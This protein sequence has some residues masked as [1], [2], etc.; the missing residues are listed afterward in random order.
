MSISN[1]IYCHLPLSTDVLTKWGF[2]TII[3]ICAVI[4]MK[5]TSYQYRNFHYKD[6]TVSQLS[7]PHSLKKMMFI[8][9]QFPFCISM[10]ICL[11]SQHY[12]G[13]LLL[14]L[15][16]CAIFCFLSVTALRQQPQILRY[17]RHRHW[18]WHKRIINS[19]LLYHDD[20]NTGY[21]LREHFLEWK[22]LKCSR[23]RNK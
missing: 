23:L 16:Q 7:Y 14:A 8:L 11:G 20:E 19:P 6:K 9:K 5:M 21:N 18:H 15:I 10:L 22:Q 4:Q 13:L 3:L 2:S 17:M 12:A 1:S